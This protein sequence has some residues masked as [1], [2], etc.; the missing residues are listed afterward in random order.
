MVLEVRYRPHPCFTVG[1]ILRA[2]SVQ[3]F[4][5]LGDNDARPIARWDHSR[6]STSVRTVRITVAN[7]SNECG[8][9]M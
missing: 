1:H 4:R 7:S 8:L 3:R 5:D 9:T 6:S 2:V